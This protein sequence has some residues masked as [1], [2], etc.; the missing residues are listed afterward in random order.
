MPPLV[1]TSVTSL[2]R[3]TKAPLFN[4]HIFNALAAGSNQRPFA[5]ETNM[6]ANLMKPDAGADAAVAADAEPVEVD[7]V[8]NVSTEG[9]K[10]SGK[11]SKKV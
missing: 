1:L 11:K 7:G 2:R 9:A 8:I 3:L 4:I 5:A 6:L 10:K